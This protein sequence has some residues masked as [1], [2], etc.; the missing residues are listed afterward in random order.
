[1]VPPSAAPT[2][3]EDELGRGVG[4]DLRRLRKLKGLTI[5]QLAD[6]AGRSVGYLSQVERGLSD[7]SLR[8]L[9]RLTSV[10]GVPLGWFFINQPGPAA[11]RG[12]VV[13]ADDRRRVGCASAGLVEELLSPDLDGSFEVFRSVFEPGAEMAT[14]ER[15]ATEEAGYVIAGRL[16]LWLEERLFELGPG[17]SFR[18]AGESYRWRN[19]GSEPAVVVWIIAPPIY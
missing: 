11:E 13:R 17:D 12:H 10:L 16:D 4:A 15:R 18:F 2:A 1:M 3:A 8:D 7:I 9:Q 5:Q 14:A 19:P 6:A